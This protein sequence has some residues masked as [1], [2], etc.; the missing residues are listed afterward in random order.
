LTIRLHHLSAPAFLMVCLLGTQA[1]AQERKL[2]RSQLPPAVQR[3]ADEQT[4]AATVRG[5][6]T[7]KDEG[8]TVYEVE[9]TVGG[10]NRDVT[11][12]STGAVLEVEEQVPFDSLPETVRAGLKQAAGAGQ[13]TNVESLT[14]RGTLVAYEAHVRTGDKRSEIQVG[15]DGKPLAHPE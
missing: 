9:M 4:K 8:R 10:R 12:D 14:K 11:L 5:Y 7:E 2:T 15:P 13:I 6:S 3:W 1:S